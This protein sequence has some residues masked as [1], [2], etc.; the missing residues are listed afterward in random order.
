MRFTG[1]SESSTSYKMQADAD[2]ICAGLRGFL[3]AS[4]RQRG[5][6]TE[7]RENSQTGT[8]NKK[9]QLINY[10]VVDRFERLTKFDE[11]PVQLQISWSRKKR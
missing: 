4:V 3:N 1:S 8:Q 2:S 7:L 5:K 10:L 11:S 9:C 6:I